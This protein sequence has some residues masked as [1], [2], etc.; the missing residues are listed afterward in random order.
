MKAYCITKTPISYNEKARIILIAADGSYHGE[1]LKGFISENEHFKMIGFPF[2]ATYTGS[3]LLAAEEETDTYNHTI[4][5]LMSIMPEGT[6]KMTW[7]EI[8][9]LI[10]NGKLI[11]NLYGKETF[12]NIMLIHEDVY[13]MILSKKIS[14]Y[15]TKY[16]EN[17]LL[18]LKKI[19]KNKL[20]IYEENKYLENMDIDL[21]LR[22]KTKIKPYAELVKDLGFDRMI[23]LVSE[24]YFLEKVLFKF[25]YLFLP[26][27]S[28]NESVSA[29]ETANFNL[30]LAKLQL[31]INNKIND[32]IVP[33]K[34]EVNYSLKK[35]E[36]LDKFEKWGFTDEM[37]KDYIEEL[38]ILSQGN[39]EFELLINKGD[40]SSKIKNIIS[41]SLISIDSMKVTIY[42]D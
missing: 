24:A 15:I 31:K 29:D 2:K 6:K 7:R 34:F 23:E 18:E 11:I 35:S 28:C 4:K 36:L 25:G 22:F 40:T 5:E 37:K 42:M 1:V 20:N 33:L 10:S 38:L 16:K 30:N 17:N 3:G 13:Q 27:F 41:D 39:N 19:M 12:V 21:E 32:D 9:K 26:F 14:T 8:E